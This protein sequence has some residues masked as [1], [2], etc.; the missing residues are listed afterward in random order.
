M[1]LEPL[2]PE[3]EPASKPERARERKTTAGNGSPGVSTS[4]SPKTH[5][6]R[7]GPLV[8]GIAL[9]V[10][11]T[12]VG[13]GGLVAAKAA[14][15]DADAAGRKL[16]AMG[17]KDPCSG[18]INRELCKEYSSSVGQIAPFAGLGIG[19]LAVAGVGGAVILYELF[20][21]SPPNAKNS[22]R[23]ALLVTPRGS[24]LTVTGSF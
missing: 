7:T 21:A 1:E 20:G 16:D 17:V 4:V 9:S 19:G 15:A 22:P 5:S 2:K 10:V 11:G 13:I 3:V 18:S 14:H 24:A 8:A 23:V 12:A 6:P